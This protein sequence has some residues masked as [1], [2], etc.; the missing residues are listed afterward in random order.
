MSEAKDA[1]TRHVVHRLPIVFGL[2][3]PLAVTRVGRNDANEGDFELRWIGLLVQVFIP[4]DP[5]WII[6]RRPR[7][8]C[9]IVWTLVLSYSGT[10]N[11]QHVI[12]VGFYGLTAIQVFVCEKEAVVN[13]NCLGCDRA[14]DTC[15]IVPEGS[16]ACTKHEGKDDESHQDPA[17][18]QGAPQLG[19]VQIL[20]AF[21]DSEAP[22]M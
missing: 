8:D 1:N 12:G 14:L 10:F 21:L 6:F 5:D 18:F 15:C 17:S 16:G 19:H 22:N 4:L 20:S 9:G 3:I 13:L 2:P 11:S 7:E